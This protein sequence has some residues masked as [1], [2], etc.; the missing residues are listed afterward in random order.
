MTNPRSTSA[1]RTLPRFEPLTTERLVI[2]PVSV[3]DVDALWLRR[4]D[5]TTARYQAWDVPYPRERA[6]ELVDAM[7]L[8]NG[9]P[10]GDGWFQLTVDDRTTQASVG[11]LALHLTFAGRCAEIGYTFA[12]VARGRGLA[13]EAAEALLRW[14]FDTLGTSR[15]SATMHPD[16]LPSTRLAE[17]VGM[18]FEAQTKNSFWLERSDGTA[19]NSDDV[20]YAVT[21]EGWAAWNERPTRPPSRLE[22]A[23]ITHTNVR[24]ALR[25]TTHRSQRR[26]VAPMEQSIA[27][28]YAPAPY[29]GEPVVPWLRLVSADEEL[30]GF[31]MLAEPSRRGRE[32]VVW[33]LLIDRMYQRRGIGRLVL[34][35]VAER[36]RAWGSPSLA[37]SWVPGPGSPERFYRS[38]GFVPTG[39]IDD[40]EVVARRAL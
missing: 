34:D 17:R 26:F 8:R 21:H 31:V 2:R 18:V 38:T 25:L 33:R 30:V 23:P 20:I 16:N 27:D 28:A 14:C 9:V 19:E 6:Q 5:A 7:C 39:E 11:D 3:D 1:G 10:P 29:H 12:P 4:N 40:D 15:V 32:T 24:A 37:T 22:L 36:A 35:V 13:T